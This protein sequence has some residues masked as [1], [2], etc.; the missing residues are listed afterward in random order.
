MRSRGVGEVR[1]R[2]ELFERGYGVGSRRPCIDASEVLSN[3]H[4][5]QVFALNEA[6]IFFQRIRFRMQTAALL[7]RTNSQIRPVQKVMSIDIEILSSPSHCAPILEFFLKTT[8]SIQ[9]WPFKDSVAYT[10]YLWDRK[11]KHKISCESWRGAVGRGEDRVTAASSKDEVELSSLRMVRE[12]FDGCAKY[13]FHDDSR[14]FCHN[15][16]VSGNFIMNNFF[17]ARCSA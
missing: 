16:G 5:F 4:R 7:T 2:L 10:A 3:K 1:R 9:R 12:S 6:T 15:G 17:K 13:I 8:R 14:G 11:Q